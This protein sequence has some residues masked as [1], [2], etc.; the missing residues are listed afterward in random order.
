MSEEK[1][2]CPCLIARDQ[3]REG[4]EVG[5]TDKMHNATLACPNRRPVPTKGTEEI[6]KRSVL[7]IGADRMALA[8]DRLVKGGRIDS[9]SEVAD[10]RLDY[11][12]PYKYGK[13]VSEIAEKEKK[14]SEY[15]DAM[16]KARRERD[17]AVSGHATDSA[18]TYDRMNLIAERLGI[19]TG[20]EAWWDIREH[21]QFEIIKAA[22][23]EKK[24]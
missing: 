11:G 16:V 3:R 8:I 18:V 13:I 7:A 6:S 9:R 2:P 23:P 1:K 19:D 24:K 14:A 4:V 17:E 10:A 5:F 20:A 12:E 15:Q 22:L 21:E